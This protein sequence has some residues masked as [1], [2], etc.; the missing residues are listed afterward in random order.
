MSH[1]SDPA[2]LVLHALRLKGFAEDDVVATITGLEPGDARDRL[3]RL[4]TDE[5]VVRRD[6]RVSGWSLTAT[7][8]GRHA[9]MGSDELN[10]SGARDTVKAA[11]Q[12]FL[13]INP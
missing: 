13:E 4:A 10:A 12:R 11:Y 7:G 2:L 9:A 8:R 1:P 3:A 5:M 6:G